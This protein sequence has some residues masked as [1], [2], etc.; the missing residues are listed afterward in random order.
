MLIDLLNDV[1]ASLNKNEEEDSLD[2]IVVFDET[3]K[4]MNKILMQHEHDRMVNIHNLD[5]YFDLVERNDKR[6]L[7]VNNYLHNRY[8]RNYQKEV[9]KEIALA[10]IIK[11]CTLSEI[12]ELYQKHENPV[13]GRNNI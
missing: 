11:K 5:A 2:K 12:G 3:D 4:K 8:G 6:F 1:K 10:L 7:E 9:L 13:K